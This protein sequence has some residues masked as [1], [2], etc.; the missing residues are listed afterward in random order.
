MI[1]EL[2]RECKNYF[3]H[4]YVNP[5]QYIH[6]GT[7]AIV[8]GQIESLP[9]LLP[10]QYYRIEGSVFNNGVHVYG[11]ATLTDEVF[12]GVIWEMCVPP[13]FV[14]L[15]AEIEQWRNEYEAALAKPYQSESF[16][17]YSRTY[18]TGSSASGGAYT[19]RDQFAA[20]LK[21]YRRLAE[22]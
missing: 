18:K 19:W 22:I 7:Y 10:G 3:L 5:A 15:A 11:E 6:A 20:W 1:S 16:V 14:A 21:P 4:D 9:F 2:C 12:Q 13:D 17:A 8:G